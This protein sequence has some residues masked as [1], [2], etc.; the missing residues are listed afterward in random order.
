MPDVR[1]KYRF[2]R[3][4]YVRSI[5]QRGQCTV[6]LYLIDFRPC[7]MPTLPRFLENIRAVLYQAPPCPAR[8][9]LDTFY[10]NS[11]LSVHHRRRLRT[12]CYAG[13]QKNRD[14]S[15]KTRTPKRYNM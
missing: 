9:R 3:F 1:L 7:R 14:D 12:F 15:E 10:L 8:V 4:P 5:R 2:I 13:A 6:D 11:T